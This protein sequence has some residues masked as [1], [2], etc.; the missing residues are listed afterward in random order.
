[1]EN[2]PYFHF[3]KLP[4]KNRAPKDFRLHPRNFCDMI[5]VI[6]VNSPI[7]MTFYST[8]VPDYVK[9]IKSPEIF[10][11]PTKPNFSQNGFAQPK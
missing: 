6:G 8:K 9:T 3:L 1:V 7:R 11:R 10:S 2:R 4:K 5:K